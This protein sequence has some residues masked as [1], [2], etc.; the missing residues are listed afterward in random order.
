MTPTP[1]Q[2]TSP[3][4]PPPPSP[5]WYVILLSPSPSYSAQSRANTTSV[6]RKLIRSYPV[7]VA[8]YAH[9]IRFDLPMG[10]RRFPLSSVSSV[11][12]IEVKAISPY[13]EINSYEMQRLCFGFD[14]PAQVV[15]NM[16]SVLEAVNNF[17]LAPIFP[18][19]NWPEFSSIVLNERRL[20][21]ALHGP[22]P[23]NV[24]VTPHPPAQLPPVSGPPPWS[25]VSW[26]V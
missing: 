9:E 4:T 1:I 24:M 12:N 10:H 2:T 14:S 21:E 6:G 26:L 13:L 20:F 25:E 5:L 23:P 16:A 19:G 8:V 11:N 15:A 17:R 18:G 22:P 3:P 7:K